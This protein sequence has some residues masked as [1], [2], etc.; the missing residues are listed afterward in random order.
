[1]S[2]AMRASKVQRRQFVGDPGLLGTIGKVFKGAV[3]GVVGAATGF[4]TGG[5]IGA[6]TGIASSL[7]PTPQAAPPPQVP[8]FVPQASPAVQ[9]MMMA[10]PQAGSNFGGSITIPGVGTISGG[11]GIGINFGP[12]SGAAA[13]P[14]A[15]QPGA[16]VPGMKGVRLNKSGYFLKSGQ[17]VAP[18]TRCVRVRRRNPLNPRA[19]SKAMSRVVSFK[20]AAKAASRISIRSGCGC[21]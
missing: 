4:I 8:T 6:I 13:A 12:G 14:A 7:L 18:G 17:Y 21:K 19:L 15:G 16:C 11:T 10:P 5:P 9:P 2:L 20:T 1:M 3:K